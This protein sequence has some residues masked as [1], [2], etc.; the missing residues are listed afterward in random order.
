M[1]QYSK[2]ILY[3]TKANIID[4]E[5]IHNLNKRAI[6]Y[7]IIQE[8][9]KVLLDLDKII[10]LDPLNSS[11]YYLKSLTYY[12]KNDINNAKIS[13]KKY[14]A[15]LNSDNFLAKIQ[16]YYLGYLLNENISKDLSNVLTNINQILN[17][18]SNN[19]L[20][21]LIRCKIHIELN[22]YYEA[23]VDLDMLFEGEY[24]KYYYKAFSYIHLLRKHSD[25]WSYL[26]KVREIDKCDFTKLGIINE[27]SKYM[28]KEK[29]VYFI[30]NLT[31]LDSKLCQ[32]QESDISS[33]SGLVLCSKNEK[34]CLDLP[35]LCNDPAHFFI[36]KINVKKILSKDCFI[37]FIYYFR[38]D[39]QSEHILKHEDVSKL[40]GLGWIEY[41][42]LT[43]KLNGVQ[44]SIEINSIEMQ[45]DYV[46]Y[47]GS[48][49]RKI[50]PMGYLLP[51]Y[52]QFLSNVPETFKDKY[53]SRKEMENLLDLNDILSKL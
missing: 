29:E 28:Y 19:E 21:L 34:L 8:Y 32:F 26:C 41:Q 6:A 12:T 1:K 2:A 22:K 36:Y 18:D 50:T 39:N 17:I 9:D 42:S 35:T 51:N 11:A 23:I 48:S 3:F 5:N 37:K 27:F 10:Q 52:H 16:L 25:F 7:Y 38:Y 4:P 43:Y 53:F 49:T 24:K 44:I 33:L 47:G 45:I 14:A 20:L 30:S 13:F 40:E 31:N 46:R 15:L